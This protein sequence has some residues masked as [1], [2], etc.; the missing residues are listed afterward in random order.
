MTCQVQGEM[1]RK[2][3]CQEGLHKSHWEGEGYKESVKEGEYGG[4]L[5]TQVCKWKNETC[6]NSSRNGGRITKTMEGWL[7]LWYIIPSFV[8]VTIYL[9][10][11]NKRKR[12]KS[13]WGLTTYKVKHRVWQFIYPVS[14]TATEHFWKKRTV[15]IFIT[16]LCVGTSTHASIHNYLR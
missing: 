16:I 11:K 7:Q 8:N 14:P 6:W 12:I 10:Y 15:K 4:I 2:G 1:L 9:K 5:C 13:H 3:P